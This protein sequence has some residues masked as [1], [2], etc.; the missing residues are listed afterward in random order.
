MGETMSI[1][2]NMVMRVIQAAVSTDPAIGVSE[3]PT[4]GIRATM[5]NLF[6]KAHDG[7]P[8]ILVKYSPIE[9]SQQDELG[10]TPLHYLVQNVKE[11]EVL[12]FQDDSGSELRDRNGYKV[13]RKPIS[14]TVQEELFRPKYRSIMRKENDLGETPESLL[15]EPWSKEQESESAPSGTP[16][17]KPTDAPRPGSF[18]KLGPDTD[19]AIRDVERRKNRERDE[20]R[21]QNKNRTTGPAA[22]E[23]E[24]TPTE[25]KQPDPVQQTQAPAQVAIPAQQ[26]P[27]PQ[28]P[29]QPA[30]QQAPTAPDTG[31]FPKK[32]GRT[33]LP[34][35]APGSVA[36]VLA[37]ER[38]LDSTMQNKKVQ[39]YLQPQDIKKLQQAK[40]ILGDSFRFASAS[41]NSTEKEAAG[42][43]NQDLF[44]KAQK[45]LQRDQQQPKKQGMDRLK[46]Y[47][48]RY[49]PYKK[50]FMQL[51]GEVA[52]KL[53]A[54]GLDAGPSIE[55]TQKMATKAR[56]VVLA[57]HGYKDQI[58][59]GIKVEAEH[60]DLLEFFR[61]YLKRNNLKMPLSDRDFFKMIAEAHIGEIPN[62]YD[63]METMEKNA[64]KD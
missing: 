52:R 37:L 9:L 39:S 60:S 34:A 15:M 45:F 19:K 35:G 26:D 56:R 6:E 64:K 7:D 53:Q 18:R 61:S 43:F 3:A 33:D 41:D 44:Q 23:P 4:T 57:A 16:V 51:P 31:Y 13:K 49:T 62:Y 14:R 50:I 12:Q 46:D 38:L 55:P 27:V 59:K 47:L 58:E 1:D 5:Q 21:R 48:L 36:P 17:K 32:P 30:P 24:L 63:Y 20:A 8:T 25:S 22:I 10:N 2:K 11:N 42:L 28:A 54:I 29:A 40:K